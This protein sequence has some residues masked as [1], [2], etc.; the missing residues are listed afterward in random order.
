MMA[1]WVKL[2]AVEMAGFAAVCLFIDDSCRQAVA[3][4]AAGRGFSCH[5]RHRAEYLGAAGPWVES[6]VTIVPPK[7]HAAAIGDAPCF[8]ENLV[9]ES[10]K[11]GL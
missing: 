9:N 4:A 5:L 3:Q 2:P 7:G 8:G 11:P 1:P 6:S 10:R